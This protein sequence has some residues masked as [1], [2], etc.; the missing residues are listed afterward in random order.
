[1]I[2]VPHGMRHTFPDG[3]DRAV[4]PAILGWIMMAVLRIQGS[5]RP[6]L[7]ACAEPRPVG[8]MPS[9]QEHL[10]GCATALA[11]PL[12]GV[13]RAR[14]GNRNDRSRERREDLAVAHRPARQRSRDGALSLC[15]G[16]RGLVEGVA[17]G[18][19][20]A[21]GMGRLVPALNRQQ[22]VLITTAV[23]GVG[24][25]GASAAA[26]GAGQDDGAAP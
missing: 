17:L 24:W 22:W 4:R 9:S 7:A 6:L 23:A 20:Q 2:P 26:G 12:D 10:L 13:V 16:G 5:P 18:G 1:M 19:L 21:A 25:A 8:A 14:G 15:R 3:I 11:G